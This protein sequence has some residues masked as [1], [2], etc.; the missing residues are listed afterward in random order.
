MAQIKCEECGQMFSENE[1][2]CPNCACPNDKKIC[3]TNT[4]YEYET[5]VKDYAD[6]GFLIAN[7]AGILVYFLTLALV[8]TQ[9]HGI[10]VFL[11]AFIGLIL[12]GA[13][14]YCGYILKA[15]LRIYANMSINLHEIN[16]KLR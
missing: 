12:L 13:Y 16:M 10:M 7:I 9:M 15:Y 1:A 14:I 5:T 6:I 4:G 3:T 11:V 8:V 2:S